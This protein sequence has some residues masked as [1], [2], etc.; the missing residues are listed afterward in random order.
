MQIAHSHFMA[1]GAYWARR[2]NGRFPHADDV[3]RP[4][5]D[6]V[7]NSGA[8][9]DFP[10]RSIKS[11][12]RLAALCSAL[13]SGFVFAQTTPAPRPA[14][15][16]PST[17]PTTQQTLQQQQLQQQQQNMQAQQQAQQAQQQQ[18]Q[19]DQV[20]STTTNSMRKNAKP[21]ANSNS[22]RSHALNPASSSTSH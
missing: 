17:V 14:T 19:A 21:A 3:S 5:I 22:L 8:Q 15:P 1:K 16:A 13:A 20:Q 18:Q 6:P 9:E 11:I 10:M 2:A 12:I 7:S 4:R